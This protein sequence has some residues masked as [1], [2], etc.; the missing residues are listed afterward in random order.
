MN[1]LGVVLMILMI[2]EM[3]FIYIAQNY[4]YGSARQYIVSRLNSVTSILSL[5]ADDPSVNFSS[6]VRNML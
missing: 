2:I 4:Y 5:Y 6:E 3:I 1:N